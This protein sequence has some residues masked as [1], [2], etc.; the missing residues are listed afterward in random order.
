MHNTSDIEPHTLNVAPEPLKA[1]PRASVHL[2]GEEEKEEVKAKGKQA[3]KEVKQ[4]GK[5]AEKEIK[6]KGEQVEKKGK[7]LADQAEK[8]GKEYAKKAKVGLLHVDFGKRLILVEG[9]PGGRVS[10][11]SILGENQGHCSTTWYSWWTHGCW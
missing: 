1:P 7:E 4:K 6:K 5:E 8:K 9:D 10:A 11:R 2:P 3:E